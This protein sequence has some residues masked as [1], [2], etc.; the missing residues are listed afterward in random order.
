M[1][2]GNNFG[3]MRPIAQVGDIVRCDG[4]G[5]K[6]FVID[7]YTHEISYDAESTLE[8]IYYDMTDVMTYDYT[9]GGQEDITVV[10][11]SD[12]ADAYL[13]EY[14]RNNTAAGGNNGEI[15]SYMFRSIME[16]IESDEEAEDMSNE[17]KPTPRELS[18]Q[19]AARRKQEREERS[20]R[21]NVLLDEINDYKA[22]ITMFGD[23]EGEY[24]ARI[25]EVKT[26]LAVITKEVE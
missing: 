1:T 23:M 22:L 4:Y 24:Q 5:G 14:R 21:V 13:A 10:C 26:E 2:S 12:K 25:D 9:L 20:S 16:D 3:S 17:Y 15:P 18:S 8:D 7:A 19:E 11:K 6:L